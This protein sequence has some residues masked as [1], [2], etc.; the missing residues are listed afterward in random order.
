MA[1]YR[2]D[3]SWKAYRK[4]LKQ[5]FVETHQFGALILSPFAA[6]ALGVIYGAGTAFE[7]LLWMVVV[8]YLICFSGEKIVLAHDQRLVDALNEVAEEGGAS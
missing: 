5:A 6:V 7:F 3:T 2:V 4:R 1:Q 8:S